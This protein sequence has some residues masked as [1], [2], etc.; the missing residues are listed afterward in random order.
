MSSTFATKF[1]SR[2]SLKV[3]VRCGFEPVRVPDLMDRRRRDRRHRP[4]CRAQ[5]P[6]SGVRRLLVERQVHD[7]LDSFSQQAACA[8]AG[9][10]ASFS[11]PVHPLGGVTAAPA[12]HG[13]RALAHCPSRRLDR[14]NPSPASVARSA[15]ATRSFCGVL[16][17][18]TSLSSRSR[19]Q[20][21]LGCV[22]SCPSQENRM[23]TLIWES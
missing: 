4:P 8:G 18:F 22:R 7:L 16:R 3:R 20:E 2:E 15:T 19:S 13:E 10:C 14:A 12:P 1:G 9:G 23:L 6:V 5:A 21:E 11:S 17:S